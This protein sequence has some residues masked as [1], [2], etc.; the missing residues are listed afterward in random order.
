MQSSKIKLI[1]TDWIINDKLKFPLPNGNLQFL[2]NKAIQEANSKNFDK[3]ENYMLRDML[4]HPGIKFTQLHDY[5]YKT[6]IKFYGD[7]SIVS[8]SEV[9]LLDNTVYLYVVELNYC[10]D[11]FANRVFEQENNLKIN[12]N[13][14]Q[15]IPPGIINLARDNK[16][17]IVFSCIDNKSLEGALDQISL[18]FSMLGVNLKNIIVLTGSKNLDYKGSLLQKEAIC[19]INDISIIMNG[20]PTLTALGY[21]SDYVRLKDLNREEFRSKKFLSWNRTINRNHRYALANLIL[22]NNMLESGYFTFL[23]SHNC[24]LSVLND[25]Y[26]YSPMELGRSC[27]D[28]ENIIPLQI[29]THHLNETAIQGFRT[30]DNNKKEIYLNSYIHIVS[31]TEFRNN[32]TPYLT[33]KTFRPIMNLQPFIMINNAGTL[34]K[35]KELGFKTFDTIID[36]SYDK[37]KDSR[38]RWAI[39]E[40]EIL[41]FNAMSIEEIHKIY[42]SVLDI[43][44]HNQEKLLTYKSYNILE[45]FMEEI[46]NEI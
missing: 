18:R 39:I 44:I 26:R 10:N 31:E 23:S 45:K 24:C 37:E 11:N 20:Y 33:E 15:Q 28:I 6:W 7:S 16:C 5:F 38:K 43:L 1:Y 41:R 30:I 35:L 34:E 8:P 40:K 14:F 22:K 27:R 19:A 17:K 4:S 3:I 46:E 2:N 29:D 12:F 21:E 32:R 42:F 9:N 25:L 36:E 13:L